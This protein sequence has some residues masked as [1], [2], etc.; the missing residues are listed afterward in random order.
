MNTLAVNDP[1]FKDGLQFECTQ[2]GNC[3]TGAP[4]TVRIS[5]EDVGRLARHLSMSKKAFRGIYTRHVKGYVSLRELPNYDCVFWDRSNGCRV[6]EHRPRQ[7]RTWPFWK[8]V[9]ESPKRWEA[10]A[11]HCP[12]MNR[13]NVHDAEFISLTI[14]NDGTSEVS[15]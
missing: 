8:A 6:Y 1:W 5:D 3:C 2:C 12:G 13:G 14:L 11:E 7:C 10:E 4:G 15:A 9:V